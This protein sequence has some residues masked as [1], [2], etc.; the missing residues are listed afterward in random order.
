[1]TPSGLLFSADT[2]IIVAQEFTVMGGLT[3][4]VFP[5]AAI[6]HFNQCRHVNWD[7]P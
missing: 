2:H 5:L 6:A 4:F 1:M 3:L 7:E